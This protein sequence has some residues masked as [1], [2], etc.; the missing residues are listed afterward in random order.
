[1]VISPS[2][3]EAALGRDKLKVYR[4]LYNVQ[5]VLDR[6]SPFVLSYGVFAEPTDAVLL[7][8]MLRRAEALLGHRLRS[9]LGD[10]SYATGPNATA[11][12]AA[13]LTLY[14][15]WREDSASSAIPKSQFVW[16][17]EELGYQ[18]PQGHVL[19]YESFKREK[20]SDGSVV[21]LSLYRCAGELCQGCPLAGLCTE[22]AAK[23][24]LVRRSEHEEAVERLQERMASASGKEA[25]R[26]RSQTVELGFADVKEHRGLRRFSGRGLKRAAAQVAVTVLARNL[27]ALVRL[28]A[29]M[30]STA[31]AAAPTA[32]A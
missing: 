17:G 22:N 12:E 5:Y 28:G 30:A 19:G 15:P 21:R 2:D 11:A 4:P 1:V 26:L 24:R 14:A 25:Y 32:K 8:P 29:K 27:V 7:G 20:Q 18:C 13:T 6:Q 10:A 31:D 23:G 9:V 3:P 16:L